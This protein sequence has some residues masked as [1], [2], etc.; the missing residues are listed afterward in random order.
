MRLKIPEAMAAGV[1]VVS[2][3][4]GAEGLDCVHGEHLLIADTPEEFA[5]AVEN[6][7][8]D[9]R[10]ADHLRWNA[11][12]LVEQ[13]YSWRY[14]GNLFVNLVEQVGNGSVGNA[15]DLV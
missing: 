6:V 13:R 2:T 10:L 3:S 5:S 7:L 8:T 14:I 11:R 4:M 1:P 15:D 12:E 9:S